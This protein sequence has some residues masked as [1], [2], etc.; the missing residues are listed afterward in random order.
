MQGLTPLL[1]AVAAL[2]FFPSLLFARPPRLAFSTYLGGSRQDYCNA[3]ALRR[4]I[5]PGTVE[6]VV[7]G[8]RS[9][10]IFRFTN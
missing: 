10:R 3:I 9:R 4:G 1:T 8:A 5:L 6:A 2:V 7:T